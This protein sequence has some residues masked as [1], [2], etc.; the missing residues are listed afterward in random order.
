MITEKKRRTT[1][2][3]KGR[4]RGDRYKQPSD[5]LQAPYSPDT[6]DIL[7]EVVGV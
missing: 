5:R 6:Q 3:F 2:R 4:L 1:S 7:T